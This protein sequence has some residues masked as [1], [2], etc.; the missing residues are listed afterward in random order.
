M[1]SG[2]ARGEWSASSSRPLKTNPRGRAVVFFLGLGLA[3][4][5][6]FAGC[7]GVA[8]SQTQSGSASISVTPSSISFGSVASG[9]MNTQTVRINNS[10]NASLNISQASVSGS[11]FSMSGLSTPA[12]IPVGQSS[13]FTIAFGPTTT[14]SYSG[15]LSITSNASNA[16]ATTISLSGS[17]FV[18]IP[19]SVAMNWAASTSTVVGYFVYRG[20]ASGGPYTKVNVTPVAPVNY[21]DSTVASGQIYFYVVTAVDANGIESVFSNEVTASVPIP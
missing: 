10:G 6:G 8:S 15:S 18:P 4:S 5:M 11:G 19:H 17:G 9:V 12:T 3:A 13:T 16:P 1:D 21:T 2:K 7:S 20:T 14:A